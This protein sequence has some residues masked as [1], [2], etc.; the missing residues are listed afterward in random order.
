VADNWGGLQVLVSLKLSPIGLRETGWYTVDIAIDE[1][2]VAQ[3]SFLVRVAP[4]Q[5]PPE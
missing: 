1:E 2:S 3:L 4:P 5:S